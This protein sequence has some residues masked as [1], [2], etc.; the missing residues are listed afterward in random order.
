MVT[1][2][3]SFLYPSHPLTYMGSENTK[4]LLKTINFMHARVIVI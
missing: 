2:F 1:F 4:A 3:V